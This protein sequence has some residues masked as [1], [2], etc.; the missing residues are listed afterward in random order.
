MDD[1][2][3]PSPPERRDYAIPVRRDLPPKPYHPHYRTHEPAAAPPAPTPASAEPLHRT[4][5]YHQ[6]QPSHQPLRHQPPVH[7]LKRRNL[8]PIIIIALPL[9]AA[10]IFVAGYSL[11]S[12]SDSGTVPSSVTNQAK[13]NVYFPSPMPSGY[14][15]MKDTATFQI[16]EVFYKFG[17]G[18]KRITVKE[19][20]AGQT[21]PDLKLLSG[22]TQFSS[23][24]GP[25]AIGSSFGQ[26]I[27]VVVTPNTVIT[28]N[29][30][31]SV[32]ADELKT[33]VS[34]LKSI[35]PNPGHKT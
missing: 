35:G 20:P 3:R 18:K 6:S 8:K 26:P 17:D 31:G 15:Y 22:Y 9:I 23:P 30:S 13:F 33:A 16:G 2:K 14:S 32:S 24:S 11:K 1:I 21:K 12:S 10:G 27:A 19:E 34:N 25:A 7:N 5:A 29:S 28:M 4:P